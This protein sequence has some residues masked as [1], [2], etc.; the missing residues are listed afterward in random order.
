MKLYFAGPYG[1]RLR[2]KK[3]AEEMDTL[4]FE[5]TSRWVYREDKQDSIPDFRR[6]AAEDWR[7]IE[8]AHAL[9]VFT[10]G[11]DGRQPLEPYSTTGGH[12]VEMGIALAANKRIILVGPPANIFH[13]LPEVTVFDGWSK[14][15]VSELAQMEMTLQSS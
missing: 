15:V 12:H 7:D 9:V 3:A 1:D 13:L 6:Y 11:E 14:D 4:G 8:N 10:H 5:I 2:I